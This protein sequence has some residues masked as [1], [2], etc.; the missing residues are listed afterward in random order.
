MIGRASNSASTV[1]PPARAPSPSPSR[2]SLLQPG[3]LPFDVRRTTASL[4]ACAL[5]LYAASAAAQS[6]EGLSA[7]TAG[8][9][10]A[11]SDDTTSAEAPADE[12]PDEL[13][14]TGLPDTGLP[15]ELADTELADTGT[16]PADAPP[17]S[18]QPQESEPSDADANGWPMDPRTTAEFR[19]VERFLGL[20]QVRRGAWVLD[21]RVS[22]EDVPWDG[23][24]PRAAYAPR[25]LVHWGIG[26]R[27]AAMPGGGAGLPAPDGPMIEAAFLLDIRYAQDLP[28]RMRLALAINYQPYD[29][30]NV[31]GGVRIAQSPLAIRLRVMALSFDLTRWLGVR[32]GPDIGMQWAPPVS[33]EGGEMTWLF[34]TSAE[35]VL[36]LLDGLLEVGL[37]GGIQSTAVGRGTRNGWEVALR[38]EGVLGA[39]VGYFFE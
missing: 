1:E 2:E 31:G 10:P 23:L 14:D 11:P 34:G 9:T 22:L 17:E 26:G 33:G 38:A 19:G 3:T 30:A 21:D 13:A 8:P 32:I 24:D 20:E 37:V 28:W 7:P 25:G 35:V 39:T 18:V 16:S 36:N 27:L 6:G 29:E 4:L 12:L 15:D 5:W